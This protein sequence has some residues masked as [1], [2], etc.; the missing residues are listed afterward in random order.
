MEYRVP[1]PE[2][3]G[4]VSDTAKVVSWL[5]FAGVIAGVMALGLPAVPT[6]VLGI[7]GA[8]LLNGFERAA[9]K[10]EFRPD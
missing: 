9:H 3:P 7:C 8:L 10:R 5:L 1:D 2:T 4:Y 6:V